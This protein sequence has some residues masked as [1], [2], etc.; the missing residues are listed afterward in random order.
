MSY[1][2]YV[3]WEQI[4]SHRNNIPSYLLRGTFDPSIRPP[5]T[6]APTSINKETYTIIL[7]H[8]SCDFQPPLN[9]AVTSCT[10]RRE[11]LTIHI[12]TA[13]CKD[14][15]RRTHLSSL[16][17]LHSRDFFTNL[18]DDTV[19]TSGDPRLTKFYSPLQ[20]TPQAFIQRVFSLVTSRSPNLCS[21]LE[22]PELEAF[23]GAKK[24][25]GEGWRVVYRNYAT[26]Y[27]VFVVDEAESGLGILD[28]IQVCVCVCVCVFLACGSRLKPYRKNSGFCRM[29]RPYF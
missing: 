12:P 15:P 19:N 18:Q 3:Y 26:L 10:L 27:F 5:W 13:S 6:E 21:F 29:S 23:F 17:N 14:D 28:L 16:P 11:I 25:S 7:Y 20:G 22:A 2:C 9:A 24:D 4:T 8:R 1:Y